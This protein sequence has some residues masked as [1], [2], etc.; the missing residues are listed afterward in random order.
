MHCAKDPWLND[1]AGCSG[2]VTTNAEQGFPASLAISNPFA[3][4]FFP[5]T[6]LAAYRSSLREAVNSALTY[7]ILSPGKQVKTT[8]PF[9]VK[10]FVDGPVCSDRALGDAL[11]AKLTFVSKGTGW[12]PGSS[13]SIDH[14][15]PFKASSWETDGTFKLDPG[16]WTLL[17]NVA[18]RA[19]MQSFSVQGGAGPASWPGHGGGKVSS[20]GEK[21]AAVPGLGRSLPLR[22]R[23]AE[24]QGAGVL[25]LVIGNPSG[26]R[27]HENEAVELRFG[28]KAVGRARL[29]RLAAGRAQR[30]VLRYALPVRVRGPIDLEIFVGGHKIGTTRVTPLARAGA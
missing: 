7:K 10:L 27:D 21:A 20:A 25:A 1:K 18:E 28:G 8:S 13:K 4:S 3:K 26:G 17:T 22:L 15:L 11:I 16:E 12:G 14:W 23:S 30:L 9:H 29:A 19:G 5:A 2:S 24:A 6:G